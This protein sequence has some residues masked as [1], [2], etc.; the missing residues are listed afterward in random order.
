LNESP[1]LIGQ[2]RVHEPEWYVKL[3]TFLRPFTIDLWLA[4][5]V[6]FFF[7]ALV[8]GSI[9]TQEYLLEA[10]E[11]VLVG[12]E[13]LQD[14]NSSNSWWRNLAQSLYLTVASFTCG[15]IFR[16]RSFTGKF[17]VL[18]WTFAVLVLV[19]SY[20]ANMASM[21]VIS[22][23]AETQVSS[24]EDAIDKRLPVCVYQGG[25][26][27]TYM[28]SSFPT[29]TINY[30]ETWSYD[31]VRNGNCAAMVKDRMSFACH[32]SSAGTQQ[33]VR[34]GLCWTAVA[35]GVWQLRGKVGVLHFLHRLCI[36]RH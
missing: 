1:Q 32:P 36:G 23:T 33:G 18:S 10:K 35:G 3:F 34:L 2:L 22:D 8:Y 7:V 20:T 27:D 15:G 26:F 12:M 6:S 21:L 14:P 28:K 29:L 24:L 30:P 16:P 19:A 31:N 17:F 4:I 5:I 25:A 11:Y 9:E 13:D